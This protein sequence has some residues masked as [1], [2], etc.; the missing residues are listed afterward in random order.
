MNITPGGTLAK[1]SRSL[2]LL[3]SDSILLM[4]DVSPC[5]YVRSFKSFSFD[6]KGCSKTLLCFIIKKILKSHERATRD[7]FLGVTHLRCTLWTSEVHNNTLRQWFKSI[8]SA[9]HI[10]YID[11]FYLSRI[12]VGMT[13]WGIQLNSC[14]LAVVSICITACQ[15]VC[16]CL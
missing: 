1:I 13:H 5:G 2:F 10:F 9:N 11:K 6:S 7:W 4:G 8:L 14:Y 12:R 3:Y 16:F 15:W